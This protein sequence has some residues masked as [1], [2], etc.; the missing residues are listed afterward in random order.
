M[1]WAAV[2][3]GAEVPVAMVRVAELVVEFARIMGAAAA[4]PTGGRAGTPTIVP[5]ADVTEAMLGLL[6]GTGGGPRPPTGAG[7][8]GG[9]DPNER[10]LVSLRTV[11]VE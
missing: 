1:V 8:L 3:G 11:E 2:G 7:A 4:V 6:G 9:A 10:E 5:I